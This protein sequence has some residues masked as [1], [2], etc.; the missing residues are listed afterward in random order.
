[1]FD[2]Q[3]AAAYIAAETPQAK[4]EAVRDSLGDGTL[5]V[6]VTAGETTHFSGTMSGP[7]VA[8]DG[9]LSKMGAP[10]GTISTT[11]TPNA[12][13]W[14]LRIANASG[15]W[16]EDSFG[17]GGRFTWSRESMTAGEVLTLKLAISPRGDT[18]PELA[19]VGL[20]SPI[21]I[22]LDD[23]FDLSAY[24][25]GGVPPYSYAVTSGSLPDGVSLDT[26]TGILTAAEDADVGESGDI[27]FT[28]TDDA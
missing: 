4:A 24:V 16:M 19:W 18:P 8:S 17:P 23:T 21:P 14:R 27:T 10:S 7:L 26:D 25:E 3:T 1:M 11:G 20:P 6:T 2:P 12:S 22:N 5:T 9:V 15:R 28:V 13:T